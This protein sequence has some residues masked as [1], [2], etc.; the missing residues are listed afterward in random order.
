MKQ[1]PNYHT[2]TYQRSGGANVSGGGGGG[3]GFCGQGPI[4]PPAR[5]EEELGTSKCYKVP[6]RLSSRSWWGLHMCNCACDRDQNMISIAV[7][8]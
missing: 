2:C 1:I 8:I 6:S 3:K 5:L 4:N 7:N